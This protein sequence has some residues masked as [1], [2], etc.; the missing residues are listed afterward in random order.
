MVS[1]STVTGVKESQISFDDQLS[2]REHDSRPG[3][4]R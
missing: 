4:L 1:R 2:A 3:K